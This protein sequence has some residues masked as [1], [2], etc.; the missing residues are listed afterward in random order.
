M[1][2]SRRP[3]EQKTPRMGALARLPLFFALEGKRAMVAGG[4]PGFAWKV[5]LLAAAERASGGRSPVDGGD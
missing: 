5:E 3:A 1:S 4:G 2:D